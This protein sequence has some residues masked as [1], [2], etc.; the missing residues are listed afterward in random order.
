MTGDSEDSPSPQTRTTWTF[1]DSKDKGT[2]VPLGLSIRGLRV[3]V[4]SAS[5]YTPVV[6][7]GQR[8]FF[9]GNPRIVDNANATAM[10]VSERSALRCA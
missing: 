3:Q 9:M 4:P 2:A 6:Q 7:P 10:L 5:L 8:A 1:V